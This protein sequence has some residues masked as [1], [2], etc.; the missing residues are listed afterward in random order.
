MQL[1]DDTTYY[2]VV[3]K[4]CEN[5]SEDNLNAV[6][7]VIDGSIPP[8]NDNC[9]EA[10]PLVI[11]IPADG[12]TVGAE[13]DFHIS[14]T[15]AF[16]GIDQTPSLAPGR[17]VVFSFTAPETTNYSFKATGYD[18]TQNLVLYVIPSCPVGSPPI[19]IANALGAANRSGVN[20][21]EEVFCLSLA[22]SQ[23]V[24]V[25]VDDHY[26]SNPGSRFTL[27]VTRCV[28]E[29]EPNN[30]PETAFPFACGI[31]GSL[32][33]ASDIDF[34]ALGSFP[35]GWRAFVMVDGEAS[36]IAN[37]DLRITTLTDTLE[38][39]DD[40]NDASFGD[41]SPN[42]AGTRLTGGRV[43]A[44]V[45]YFGGSARE[46]YRIHAVVQPPLALAT[47][48]TEPNNNWLEAN[49]SEQNYFY[50]T[51]SGPGLSADTDVYAFS[52]AEGDLIFVSLD[53]DPYRTNAPINARLELLDSGGN[54]L[55]VVDDSG[56]ASFGGTNASLNTLTAFGP[57]SP[58]EALTYRSP[59]EGTFYARVSISSGA[60]GNAR[61]GNYLLSIS[62]NCL[63]GLDGLN[64]FPVLTNIVL[65]SSV[66]VGTVT[67][68]TGA[69]WDPDLGD[70]TAATVSWGDGTTNHVEFPIPGLQPFSLPHQFNVANTNFTV[71][72]AL[73]D[74]QGGTAIWSTN[75]AVRVQSEAAR[76]TSITPLSNGHFHLEL[77]GTPQGL[78]RIEKCDI[79]GSAWTEL[80]TRTAGPAGTFS[81]DDPNP[82]LSS[83]FYRAMSVP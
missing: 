24:F 28:R 33:P 25:V 63:T 58:A 68:L 66:A 45:N 39:D 35:P 57:S 13:D 4:Y 70:R 11:N 18:V 29:G 46:P 42:V 30:S 79:L 9:S 8:P 65:A 50:G 83:R 15:G 78:Y 77:E 73:K 44:S 26:G 16:S 60:A 19:D 74:S 54:L 82:A 27:E 2:I 64:H 53:G 49:S 36:R 34:Y 22:A 6:Q 41:S 59:I 43:F 62:R 75:I 3:W 14:G 12:T 21:T 71:T 23:E 55:V 40:N 47:V 32:S 20:S 51:L 1:L 52:V 5:C 31:S 80:G 76:F 7:L 81:I 72:I 37:Y 69:S 17:D 38:F 56:A 10:T 48:E 61:S 67:S